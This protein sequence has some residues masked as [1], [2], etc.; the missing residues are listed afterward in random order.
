MKK[1]KL[2]FSGSLILIFILI[3]FTIFSCTNIK[4][5]YYDSN[6]SF[7]Q[8]V[9]YHVSN[10]ITKTYLFIKNTLLNIVKFFKNIFF[11][12]KTFFIEKFNTKRKYNI[13][14]DQAKTPEE[15]KVE[16]NKS[17]N[18]N[19][20]YQNINIGK[21]INKDK[22]NNDFILGLKYFYYILNLSYYE[23]LHNFID[24]NEVKDYVTV[25]SNLKAEPLKLFQDKNRGIFYSFIFKNNNIYIFMKNENNLKFYKLKPNYLQEI[26][27]YG[28]HIYSNL[29]FKRNIFYYYFSYSFDKFSDNTYIVKGYKRF[30]TLE[31]I[32]FSLL[33]IFIIIVL[34]FFDRYYSYFLEY[35][36][37]A[38]SNK[39]LEKTE[40]IIDNNINK[41]NKET[42]KL[43]K[44]K[45]DEVKEKEDNEDNI[46]ELEDEILNL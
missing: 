46:E 11:N 17:I 3:L 29:N 39:K 16:E 35:K 2:I 13:K 24:S 14:R 8:K 33:L 21:K 34:I 22:L 15:K 6:A 37:I 7:I 40:K 5:K 23:A 1:K 44:E 10:G 18:L 25:V 36:S 41:K 43:K 42:K 31:I 4:S 27:N 26:E 32:L 30:T 45:K 20:N 19:F 28:Y 12:V 9:S 38:K